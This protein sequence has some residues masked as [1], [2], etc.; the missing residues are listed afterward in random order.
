L[1]AWWF[2]PRDGNRIT[3]GFFSNMKEMEFVPHSIGRGSDWLLVIE[4][5]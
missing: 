5:K 2:N 3:L 1:K 4:K